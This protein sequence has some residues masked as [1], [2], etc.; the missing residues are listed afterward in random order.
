MLLLVVGKQ[1]TVALARLGAA[2]AALE[3][4]VRVHVAGTGT[5]KVR[6]MRRPALL[7]QPPSRVPGAL[8][9]QV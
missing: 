3:G 6:A 9:G 8:P 1:R 2:V 4:S 7:H 5:A